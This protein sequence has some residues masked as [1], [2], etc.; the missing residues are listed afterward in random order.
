MARCVSEEKK[1]RVVISN[2]KYEISADAP[3]DKGG[4]GSAIRPNELLECALAGCMN[5][6]LRIYAD[7]KNIPLKKVVTEVTADRDE[8]GEVTFKYSISLDGPI[9]DEQKAE[10]YRIAEKCPVRKMLSGEIYFL[11]MD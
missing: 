2:G 10:L 8:P 11:Q 3:V 9:T 7:K 4:G 5:M 6:T 1:Y